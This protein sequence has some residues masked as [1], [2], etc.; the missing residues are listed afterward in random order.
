[1][2]RLGLLAGGVLLLAAHSAFAQDTSKGEVSG[3]WR[4]YHATIR[5]SVSLTGASDV[6]DFSKGW[7]VD[8]SGNLSPK[9]AVVGDV[10]GTYQ[11]DETSPT[12]G[13]VRTSEVTDLKLYTFM[14]GIRVRAPQNARI[15]PFGQV[16]VGGERNISDYTRT[17]TFNI[18]NASIPPSTVSLE[19]NTSGAALALDG[20]VTISVGSIGVRT[21][22]GYVR[23]FGDADVDAFRF[24]LGGV[25]RF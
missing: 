21:Q 15:I 20:G 13:L 6:N 11:R 18:P 19:G 24:S 7:Y 9:F 10:G 23:M 16:L 4:Y 14:G 25:F 1:M 12:Q 22:A 17:T 8:V 2:R 3:G 5:S